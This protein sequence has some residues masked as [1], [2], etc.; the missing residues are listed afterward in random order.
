M[1]GTWTALGKVL[2]NAGAMGTCTAMGT[3]GAEFEAMGVR[4]TGTPTGTWT[5]VF[6]TTCTSGVA[7]LDISEL[8]AVSD[9]LPIENSF[10]ES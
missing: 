2:T 8:V 1:M 10:E 4:T 5:R 3:F 6:G 7:W 9:R